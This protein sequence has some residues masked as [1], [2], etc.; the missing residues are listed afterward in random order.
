MYICQ[1]C[2]TQTEP[3]VPCHIAPSEVRHATYPARREANDPG[4]S[5]IEIVKEVRAC[6]SCAA[7]DS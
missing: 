2:G 5:G 7:G 6:P 4:G 3:G 1:I